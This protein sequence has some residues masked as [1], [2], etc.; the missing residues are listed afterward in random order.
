MQVTTA[1]V[2]A[3]GLCATAGGSRAFAVSIRLLSVLALAGLLVGGAHPWSDT[4]GSSGGQQTLEQRFAPPTGYR[5]VTE[6]TG[7]FGAWLRTL[8][9]KS[10]RPEVLL[11]TGQPK[12][13]Q[14]AHVA[15]LDID[16]GKR[17]LQQCA[18]ASM[19]LRAEYL[20]SVGKGAAI[21]FRAAAGYD[22][23]WTKWRRG[24]RSPATRG[25][26]WQRS[27]APGR[28]YRA[29]RRYLDKVF[30]VA[31]TASI[32][33]QLTPVDPAGLQAG[34]VFIE[35][36]SGGYYGHAVTVMDVVEDDRGRRRFL[37]SQ[38]YMPAQQMHILKGVGDASGPWYAP[39]KTGAEFTTPEWTFPPDSLRRFKP[40]GC[41]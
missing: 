36:A 15:V 23:P 37:L 39:P 35:G 14:S 4:E 9:V 12:G 18:D 17:D 11:H 25:G 13:N 6:P 7:S 24:L 2:R 38:S 30:G 41:R 27:A 28:S 21:C 8:P 32:L 16:V 5:R 31:N 26:Q 34:D 22:L 1:S 3:A 33:R 10:G 19:R 29:F 40:G 20:R